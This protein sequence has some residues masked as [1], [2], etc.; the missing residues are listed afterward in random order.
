MVPIS[1]LKKVQVLQGRA[2]TTE[3]DRL[4]FMD[5]L[6]AMVA[7]GPFKIRPLKRTEI[8]Y[9]WSIISYDIDEPILAAESKKVTLFFHA[10]KGKI[11]FADIPGSHAPTK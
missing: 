8:E 3:A 5:T 9:Y 10:D 2:F 6:S 1:D 11:M 7:L 4:N